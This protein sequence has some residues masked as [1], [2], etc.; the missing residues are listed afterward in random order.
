MECISENRIRI[1]VS[2]RE[3]CWNL[4]MGFGLHAATHRSA[5]EL[6]QN[7]YSKRRNKRAPKKNLLLVLGGEA[8]LEGIFTYV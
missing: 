8:V 3:Y 7:G 4:S 2:I 6:E 1:T 5:R